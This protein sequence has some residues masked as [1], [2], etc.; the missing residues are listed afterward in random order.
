[1]EIAKRLSRSAVKGQGH[2]C[3]ECY[4]GGGIHFDVVVLRLTCY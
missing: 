1:V 4:D 2:M 3:I